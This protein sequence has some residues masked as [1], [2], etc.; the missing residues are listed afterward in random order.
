MRLYTDLTG[1]L[2]FIN[3]AAAVAA[4]RFALTCSSLTLSHVYVFVVKHYESNSE[5]RE[6]GE[7]KP[8]FWIRGSKVVNRNC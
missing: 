1:S 5:A 8:F 7:K 3:N 6:T 2:S 4:T